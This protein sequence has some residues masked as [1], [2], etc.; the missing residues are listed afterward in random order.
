MSEAVKFIRTTRTRYFAGVYAALVFLTTLL[1]G[2]RTATSN[3]TAG[4]Y[5]GIILAA[6]VS[7]LANLVFFYIAALITAW[8]IVEK[9]KPGYP[10]NSLNILKAT[11][12]FTIFGSVVDTLLVL[13]APQLRNLVSLVLFLVLVV[14][15]TML[16]ARLYKVSA[17]KAFFGF[18]LAGIFLGLALV[19]LGMVMASFAVVATMAR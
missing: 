17:L 19:A 1:F 6:V 15:M 11:L 2:I 18:L 16:I 8:V 12:A 7:V 13:I 10:T 4:E 14:P 5:L 9:K 3:A